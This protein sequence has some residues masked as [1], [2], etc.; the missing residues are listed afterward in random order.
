MWISVSP[1][2]CVCVGVRRK[3]SQPVQVHVACSTGRIARIK[4]V[5]TVARGATCHTRVSTSVHCVP[6]VLGK[7]PVAPNSTSCCSKAG[8]SC[9]TIAATV[10][11]WRQ[12]QE[13]VAVWRHLRRHKHVGEHPQISPC[14]HV[15]HVKA[16]D[17]SISNILEG[18]ADR[19]I[20][21]QSVE[22]ENC[23][24]SVGEGSS[25]VLSVGPHRLQSTRSWKPTCQTGRRAAG[26][27]DTD[28]HLPKCVLIDSNSL[29]VCHNVMNSRF[30]I[31]NVVRDPQWACHHAPCTQ[32]IIS[33]VWFTGG[34]SRAGRL[35]ITQGGIARAHAQSPK[36]VLASASVRPMSPGP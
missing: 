23:S 21:R 28:S 9:G 36:C 11:T 8:R 7:S 29:G 1:P 34:Q 3:C 24:I 15:A 35:Q 19:Q 27:V 2:E 32:S 26:T 10:G 22:D 30:A 6:S 12:P 17:S 14:P 20:A 4:D 5:K 13:P 33:T 31:E 16:R 25:E 18:Q